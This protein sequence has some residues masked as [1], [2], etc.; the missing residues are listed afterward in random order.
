MKKQILVY[1]L[2]LVGFSTFAQTA[3]EAEILK[4]QQDLNAE[5]K[6]PEESPLTAEEQKVFEGHQFYPIDS[7]NRVV[8]DF[9]RF[10]KPKRRRG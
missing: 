5:Y 3:Y 1:A 4:F 2:I 9:K 10:R 6:N 8:A 7:T